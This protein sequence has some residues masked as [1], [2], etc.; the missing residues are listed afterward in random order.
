MC[1]TRLESKGEKNTTLILFMGDLSGLMEVKVDARCF[2]D[3]GD[4]EGLGEM[5]VTE[6]NLRQEVSAELSSSDTINVEGI[7]MT[8]RGWGGGS[9]ITSLQHTHSTSL[10]SKYE[11]WLGDQTKQFACGLGKQ[12]STG[13]YTHGR[14]ALYQ[15]GAL[16]FSSTFI[17][18]LGATSTGLLKWGL[19][20]HGTH[21]VRHPCNRV[22]NL[23]SVSVSLSVSLSRCYN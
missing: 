7:L 4:E 11:L 14:L 2:F 18:P 16:G 12:W 20:P 1:L 10:Q 13:L 21:M 3:P 15:D 5:D 23:P 8:E 6:M 19:S 17:Q 9:C 22:R